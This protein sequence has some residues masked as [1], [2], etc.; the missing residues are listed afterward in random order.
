MP[1]LRAHEVCAAF[2]LGRPL[3]RGHRVPGGFTHRTWRLQTEGGTYAVK[4]LHQYWRELE[5][6]RAYEGTFELESQAVEAGLPAAEPVIAPDGSWLV[7]LTQGP[8]RVH[9][10]VEGARLRGSQV[11][12]EEAR[13][14]GGVLAGI[15]QLGI[16]REVTAAALLPLWDPATWDEYAREVHELRGLRPSM[17]RLREVVAAGRSLVGQ[18]VLSHGDLNV[19]NLLRRP[20]GVLVLLDW[21]SA[22]PVDPAMDAAGAAA[23]LGGLLGNAP[24]P[25]VVHAFMRGYRD[26]GGE[27]DHADGRVFAGMLNGLHGWLFALYRRAVSAPTAAER[28]LSRRLAGQ[29][30][31]RLPRILDS[32]DR[33]AT[34]LG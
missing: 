4:L 6:R 11:G 34:L 23:G 30:A 9:R 2:G 29:L 12:V 1:P 10:W 5:R 22:E 8:V 19:K 28:T 25:A 27:L 26:G 13:H 3:S 15:H 24:R 20:D 17:E 14:L 33:W 32:L 21:D 31:R 16:H 7:D 18:P